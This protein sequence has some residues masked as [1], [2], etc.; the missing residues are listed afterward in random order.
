MTEH[1]PRKGRLQV[2][3]LA[4][5]I[6]TSLLVLAILEAAVRWLD[7]F[8]EARQT[9]R[10]VPT[11]AKP[12][13]ERPL[14]PL[15]PHPF[16]GWTRHPPRP[17]DPSPSEHQRPGLFPDGETTWFRA[18][19]RINLFG[20]YS[21][22]R[23]YR[24][25]D[26]DDFVVGVFGGSVAGD[27]A[28][29]AGDVLVEELERRRPELAG[30]VRLAS[31]AQG[32]YKQPQQLAALTEA[33]LLGVPFDAVVNLDGVNEVVLGNQFARRGYHP[34]YPHRVLLTAAFELT[35][36]TPTWEEI[37]LMATVVA[38]SRVAERWRARARRPLAGRLEL[39]RSLAGAL[40]LRAE[41]R[42]TVAET[43]LRDRM[44]AG[45]QRFAN[46]PEPC[47]W[48]PEACFPLI[49]DI[50]GRGSRAMA[51]LVA[52]QAAG[53]APAVYVHFLQP[54]QYVEGSKPLSDEERATAFNI[55][56]E[57]AGGVRNGYE[58]LRQRGRELRSEGVRTVD[59][60]MLFESRQETLYCDRCCHLNLE[61]NRI[62]ARAVA[63]HLDAALDR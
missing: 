13:A 4:V 28:L 35:R 51:A 52:D 5:A 49:A 34:L 12:D 26:H 48:K 27:L 30:T 21:A 17:A 36:G 54:N 63:A 31:F 58:T 1:E 53:G 43:G 44:L 6:V 3:N 7:L 24:E 19:N 33:M 39:V 42:A 55:R 62:L 61:G 37:D 18:N 59:L 29:M 47:L 16:L 10:T 2:V 45:E 11:M 60:T 15:R 8:A 25:L 9:T 20:Q 38:Q 56:T 32:G 23:D 57:W 40:A 50:W 22:I 46:L 41:R 14:S